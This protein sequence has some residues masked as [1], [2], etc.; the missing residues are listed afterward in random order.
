MT[1]YVAV[2]YS[3]V[4]GGGRRLVMADLR[5]MAASLGLSNP[6]TLAATG[7]LVFEDEGSTLSD[8]ERRLEKAFA[9]RF[10]KSV[11]II[12]R[13]ATDW[14]EMVAGN[15]FAKEALVDPTRVMVRVQRSAAKAD[16]IAALADYCTQGERVVVVGKDIWAHF[17]GQ[18]SLSRLL[19]AMV[20]K[21][22]GVGTARNWNTARRIDEM[23]EIF[24]A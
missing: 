8:L 12:V 23:L 17:T 11:P 7:N 2:L 10:D 20:P 5:D 19:P 21:R 14:R 13:T 3:V 4:L 24:E 9:H 18:A 1:R 15:P 16:A 6:R 22:L